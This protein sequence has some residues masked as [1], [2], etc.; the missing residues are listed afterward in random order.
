MSEE[1]KLKKPFYRKWWVW[2]IAIVVVIAVA[3]NG[4][5][6]EE[7]AGEP[8]EITQENETDT[9]EDEPAE[10]NESKEE[11]EPKEESTETQD[12]Q[13]ESTDNQNY[14]DFFVSHASKISNV[15]YEISDLAMDYR[16]NDDDW[17]MDMAVALVSLEEYADEAIEYEPV[18]ETYKNSHKYYAEAMAEFKLATDYFTEGIDNEDAELVDKASEHILNG[19]DLINKSNEELEKINP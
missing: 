10:E 8:E 16:P 12:K 1:T 2:V 13:N 7:V 19:N 17:V 18:P 15:L 5:D 14:I 9:L 3:T 11:D 4:E 6:T